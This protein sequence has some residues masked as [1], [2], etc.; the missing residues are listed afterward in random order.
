MWGLRF[1]EKQIPGN[2]YFTTNSCIWRSCGVDGFRRSELTISNSWSFFGNIW[3]PPTNHFFAAPSYLSSPRAFH[4]ERFFS[5]HELPSRPWTSDAYF[6][7]ENPS[8]RLTVSVSYSGLSW[9]MRVSVSHPRP[10]WSIM[11]YISYSGAGFS[12]PC[13]FSYSR[14]VLNYASFIVELETR[15]EIWKLEV[16]FETPS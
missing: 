3:A 4:H 13:F 11:V 2:K 9:S 14:A 16:W 12:Y 7:F 1:G 15:L 6:T 5:V 10:S 8:W